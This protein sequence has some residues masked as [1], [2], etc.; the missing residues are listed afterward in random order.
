[1]GTWAE[2]KQNLLTVQ[3]KT[4]MEEHEMKL[5]HMEEKHQAYMKHDQECHDQKIKISEEHAM[6]MQIL[7]LQRDQLLNETKM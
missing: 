3:Q 4:H 2:S 5:R 1:M 7:Q 6:K